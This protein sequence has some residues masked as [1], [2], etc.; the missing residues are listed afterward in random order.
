M[1]PTVEEPPAKK[2]RREET[3]ADGPVVFDE[4]GE[5]L[6]VVGAEHVDEPEVFS[7]CPK[8][9]SRLSKVFAKMLNGGFAESRP[10]DEQEGWEIELPEDKPES[11]RV[12]M[13]IMHGRVHEVPKKMELT[14]LWDVIIAADKYDVLY[15]LRP[16]GWDE[17]VKDQTD[18]LLLLGVAWYFKNYGL[19]SQMM[20]RIA[21]NCFCQDGEIYCRLGDVS[22]SGVPRGLPDLL[23]SL[24]PDRIIGELFRA[25]EP[26]TRLTMNP[27]PDT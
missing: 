2:S 10:G 15:L 4:P 1:N 19:F 7:V 14:D 16:W 23:G 8:A 3:Q 6:L 25:Q 9:L 27:R 13:D 17:A 22:D 5:L 11:L 21:E 12:L 18:N 20:V 24:V 26:S